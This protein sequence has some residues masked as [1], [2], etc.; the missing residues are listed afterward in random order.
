[1]ANTPETDNKPI[2]EDKLVFPSPSQFTEKQLENLS[3]ISEKLETDIEAFH[4]KAVQTAEELKAQGATAWP[5]ELL[6]ERTDLRSRVENLYERMSQGGNLPDSLLRDF[7]I[8]RD[9][10]YYVL[11]DIRD[12]K[13]SI[14]FDS[15]ATKIIEEF[16]ARAAEVELDDSVLKD[17][18]FRD[19]KNRLV[20]IARATNTN[21]EALVEEVDKR[22]A[23]FNKE[24]EVLSAEVVDLESDYSLEKAEEV[25]KKV[26][27]LSK[28]I[29]KIGNDLDRV[30]IH[31]SNRL[32]SEEQYSARDGVNPYSE[33][34]PKYQTVEKYIVLL[35]QGNKFSGQ[36]EVY[37]PVSDLAF[38]IGDIRSDKAFEAK[39]TNLAKLD[40]TENPKDF[41]EE[42]REM[43]NDLSVGRDL[44]KRKR[45]IMSTARAN[46]TRAVQTKGFGLQYAKAVMEL[47][48]VP[49]LSSKRNRLEIR[50]SSFE[51]KDNIRIEEDKRLAE[52]YSK[53]LTK[54]QLK[55]DFP[56]YLVDEHT[57][58][59][60][61][62]SMS[63]L[64]LDSDQFAYLKPRLRG[65]KLSGVEGIFVRDNIKSNR[66]N[67]VAHIAYALLAGDP[68]L[69]ATLES[70]KRKQF[71][72]A[73]IPADTIF[74]AN[75]MSSDV[76]S[77]NP[78]TPDLDSS[79]GEIARIAAAGIAKRA[80][81]PDRRFTYDGTGEFMMNEL[82]QILTN[83][84]ME[85]EE[86]NEIT[87]SD[88]AKAF[89]KADMHDTVS[90]LFETI[91]IMP[92]AEVAQIQ[93]AYSEAL[94]KIVEISNK[95]FRSAEKAEVIMKQLAGEE[96]DLVSIEDKK[97][98]QRYLQELTYYDLEL[99]ELRSYYDKK[100]D[101]DW[102]DGSMNA[103]T[104]YW[105]NRVAK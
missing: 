16:A 58:E 2:T 31:Y 18:T 42:Y 69:L 29:L 82:D 23:V 27:D 60:S 20:A 68:G 64:N 84:G 86:V 6:N 98:A 10:Y 103:A 50:H 54:E 94:P 39:L 12:G 88:R 48:Y 30:G 13:G 34:H 66:E 74:Q 24:R 43:L 101:G 47:G 36:R 61:S 89:R 100:I 1:M 52:V 11:D 37:R 26:Q 83:R 3:L 32:S 15:D 99:G 73:D 75:E 25:Y 28:R 59:G 102:G 38:K 81:F 21:L 80:D 72:D 35:E 41:F 78:E 5:E 97:H 55:K 49:L 53:Y 14:F 70:V 63:I 19:R 8:D 65:F 40:P 104:K 56:V 9:H 79:R 7:F 17:D 51:H 62:G 22:A 92:A 4:K 45:A 57:I 105:Q 95:I 71:V 33:G 77:L 96:K 46:L 85:S 91:K 87:R 67:E 93:E 44:G 76:A 90:S